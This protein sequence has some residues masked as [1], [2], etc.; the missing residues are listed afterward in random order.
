MRSDAG[1]ILRVG[2]ALGSGA[3]GG[4]AE[5]R[6]ALWGAQVVHQREPILPTEVNEFDLSDAAVKVHTPAFRIG[7]IAGQAQVP[8]EAVWEIAGGVGNIASFDR[9]SSQLLKAR[10]IVGQVTH[11]PHHQRVPTQAQLLQVNQ[12]QDLSGKVRQQVI[13]QAK[14]TQGVQLCQ[15]RWNA[16]DLVVTQ[17]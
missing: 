4:R 11:K 3:L 10:G 16:L 12:V 5:G 13:V 9:A 15:L 1:L 14:G 8:D 7:A 17:N 2:L 6:G